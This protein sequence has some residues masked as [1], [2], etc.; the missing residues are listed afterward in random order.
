M[1]LRRILCCFVLCVNSVSAAE[2]DT[3]IRLGVISREENHRPADDNLQT[4][5]FFVEGRLVLTEDITD[6]WSFYSDARL[7]LSSDNAVLNDDNNS[8][9]NDGNN[10]PRNFLALREAWFRYSGFTDLPNE[11]LTL[12][13]QRA[14]SQ[15]AI[16]WDADIESIMWVGDSTVLDWSVGLG[17]QFNRYRTGS[18]LLQEA[19]DRR[20]L[21]GELAWDWQAYHALTLRFMY[22]EQDSASVNAAQIR[23][24]SAGS[25]GDWLWL[26]VGVDSD[27]GN[28]R[29]P[30]NW[31]YRA[32]FMH[33]SGRADFLQQD[34][35]VLAQ[36]ISA[37][38]I[39]AG[40]RYDFSGDRYA[41]GATYI[42]ADGGDDGSNFSQTGLHSNRS[43]FAGNRQF[44]FRF[45]EALRLDITN[46]Q[47]LSI[48]GSYTLGR[49]YEA[50]ASLSFVRRNNNAAPVFVA[51]RPIATVDGEDEVG[52]GLDMSMS[53][54]TQ[55]ARLPVR[56]RVSGGY[57][58]P[59]SALLVQDDDYRI[60][61]ETQ[62]TF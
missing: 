48:F 59:S 42:L 3:T 45:N 1:Y 19:E 7:Q 51:G 9:L 50:A 2:I 38:A 57:F 44:L 58:S 25:N 61:I 16:W 24:T 15:Q 34:N 17:Q 23:E 36:D 10:N 28:D 60:T 13:L 54:Y 43:K 56:F 35:T 55:I 5:A 11:Y 21:F 37:S 20:R 62:V 22:A 29:S 40:I 6:A 32:E 18:E 12:G 31:A 46:L 8:E 26:G 47:Q 49:R 52:T 4:D 53:Y 27:W 33:L 39:D 14:R 41:L 30:A